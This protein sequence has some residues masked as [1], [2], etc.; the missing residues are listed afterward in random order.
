MSAP[1]T[2]KPAHEAEPVDLTSVVDDLLA[3][4]EQTT[5][6]LSESLE[7]GAPSEASVQHSQAPT[8]A[9]DGADLEAEPAPEVEIAPIPTEADGLANVEPATSTP[10]AEVS[11]ETDLLEQQT[12]QEA[13]NIDASLDALLD[14][15]QSAAESV[16]SAAAVPDP[17]A[18]APNAVTPAP[19]DSPPN[20]TVASPTAD[21]PMADSLPDPPDAITPAPKDEEQHTAVVPNI[22]ESDTEAQSTPAPAAQDPVSAATAAT[23]ADEPTESSYAAQPSPA[24]PPAPAPASIESLDEQLAKLTDDLLSDATGEAPTIPPPEP[25][26]VTKPPLEPATQAPP[27]PVSPLASKQTIAEVSSPP[28]PTA[29]AAIPAAERSTPTIESRVSFSSRVTSLLAPFADK[30]AQLLAGPLASLPPEQRKAAKLLSG[31]TTLVAL[32]FWG[33]VLFRP[34]EPET[35]HAH[36]D[37][38]HDTLPEIPNSPEGHDNA[39]GEGGQANGAGAHGEAAGGHGEAKKDDGHGGGGHGASDTKKKDKPKA[40]KPPSRSATK[41]KDAKAGGHGEAKK[42][43]GHGGH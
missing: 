35:A 30:S 14:N 3:R 29:P 20:D 39:H 40:P 2:H 10:V 7:K 37:L 24:E 1:D 4:I 12:V 16:E 28:V 6:E 31:W 15:I 32:V 19:T 36:F 8:A 25:I 34:R 41:K 22:S 21:H 42:D 27:S 13:A 33:V 17:L 18:A 43:A 23:L 38:A 5:S 26:V 11:S 9:P